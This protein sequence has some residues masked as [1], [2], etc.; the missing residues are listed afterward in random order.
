M[1]ASTLRALCYLLWLTVA[2]EQITGAKI[3]AKKPW[4]RDGITRREL[5]FECVVAI[6]RFGTLMESWAPHTF[7][8]LLLLWGRT[9]TIF[10][11]KRLRFA[12]LFVPFSDIRIFFRK[13]GKFPKNPLRRELVIWN[14]KFWRVRDSASMSSSRKKRLLWKVSLRRTKGF[15]AKLNEQLKIRR[16]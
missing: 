3:E 11:C 10:W 12:L 7:C 16:G 13:S 15:C 9:N 4:G 1:S 6:F 8:S 2:V 5:V 14:G